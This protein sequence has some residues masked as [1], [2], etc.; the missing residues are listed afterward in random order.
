[1][2]ILLLDFGKQIFLLAKGAA[3]KFGEIYTGFNFKP[4]IIKLVI[5]QEELGRME[6]PSG[7]C[8]GR[9]TSGQ[10]YAADTLNNKHFLRNVDGKYM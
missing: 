1:V 7:S 2:L 10:V 6:Q 5:C 4:V 8:I 3:S 9:G